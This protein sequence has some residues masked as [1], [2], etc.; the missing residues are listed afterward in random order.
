MCGTAR[1]RVIDFES[2]NAGRFVAIIA[3]LAATTFGYV[4]HSL[5][6]RG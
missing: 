2:A 1:D 5:A 3:G 4:E 6:H